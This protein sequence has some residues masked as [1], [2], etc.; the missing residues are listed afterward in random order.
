MT[1]TAFYDY[2]DE[3]NI[4]LTAEIDLAEGTVRITGNDRAFSST[5]LP[6]FLMEIL[7]DGGLIPHL[8][9]RGTSHGPA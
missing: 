3:G 4:A 7:N 9:G 6:A 2:A 1:E 5:R 8:A